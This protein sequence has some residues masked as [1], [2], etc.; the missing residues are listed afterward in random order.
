MSVVALTSTNFITLFLYFYAVI[1]FDEYFLFFFV[2]AQI[3][4]TILY[5]LSGATPHST[6][7]SL[8]YLAVGFLDIYLPHL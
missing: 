1:L 2:I 6:V 4:C 3:S 5:F 7:F 8:Q